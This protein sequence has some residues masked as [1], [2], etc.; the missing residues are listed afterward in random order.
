MRWINIFF[1]ISSITDSTQKRNLVWAIKHYSYQRRIFSR[2]TIETT[3][4]EEHDYADLRQ[5]TQTKFSLISKN[6]KFWLC[7]WIFFHRN[8]WITQYFCKISPCSMWNILDKTI[9]REWKF[10]TLHFTIN[11]FNV[12]FQCA[13]FKI[14]I[15]LL[16]RLYLFLFTVTDTLLLPCFVNIFS[17][18]ILHQTACG[19]IAKEESHI[20]I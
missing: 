5:I 16:F 2:V 13:P 3:G 11:K 6:Y 15:V 12:S 1:Y 4:K 19:A 10:K 18:S 9:K 8:D 7:I 20:T 17:R 14:Q